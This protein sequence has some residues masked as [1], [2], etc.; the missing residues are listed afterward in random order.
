MHFCHYTTKLIKLLS[1]VWLKTPSFWLSCVAVGFVSLY[2]CHALF[3]CKKWRVRSEKGLNFQ[4]IYINS[5]FLLLKWFNFSLM[6]SVKNTHSHNRPC[7]LFVWVLVSET[8]MCQRMRWY[9]ITSH[10]KYSMTVHIY[11]VCG[12]HLDKKKK[13]KLCYTSSCVHC[14][15]FIECSSI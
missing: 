1:T 11:T 8:Y 9:L 5:S 4:V 14:C 2:V 3:N 10:I 13:K 15:I 7:V 12:E 6:Q